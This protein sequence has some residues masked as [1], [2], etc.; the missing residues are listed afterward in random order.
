MSL[1]DSSI[2]SNRITPV[3]RIY[4]ELRQPAPS[5]PAPQ[6]QPTAAQIDLDAG[7]VQAILQNRRSATPAELEHILSR[8]KF[9][10][11]SQRDRN[12]VSVRLTVALASRG[13]PQ[14]SPNAELFTLLDLL[15]T[16]VGILHHRSW[17]DRELREGAQRIAA[18]V[19]HTVPRCQCW[20]IAR[21]RLWYLQDAFGAKSPESFMA[22]RMFELFEEMES[23][24]RPQRI[25][26]PN[27]P[28]QPA[29]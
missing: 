14:A 10:R 20:R 28:L 18:C 27:T 6:A 23:A 24:E 21:E 1:T 17:F 25:A 29:P 8:S 19:H 26:A 11:L 7:D 3:E 9:Y 4:L 22:T 12:E 5:K 13:R 15:E 16:P 2:S